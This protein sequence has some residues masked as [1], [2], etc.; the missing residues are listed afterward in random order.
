MAKRKDNAKKLV[1]RRHCRRRAQERFGIE[2]TTDLREKTIYAIKNNIGRLVRRQSNRVS[3]WERVV[4]G[5][6]EIQVV[7]DK[8][9]REVVTVLYRK[10]EKCAK[11]F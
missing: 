2:F 4:P 10:R 9:R 8:E 6:P 3:I 5:Y 7:Y 1:E 11:P